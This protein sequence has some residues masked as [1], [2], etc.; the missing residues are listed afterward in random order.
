M[1]WGKAKTAATTHEYDF[2]TPYVADLKNILDMDA[3]AASGLKIGV[4]PMG[5]ASLPY[6]A[7]DCRP[8]RPAARDRQQARRRIVFAL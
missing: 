2:V 7:A 5:G 4:D 8:V 1:P 6:L 3:I